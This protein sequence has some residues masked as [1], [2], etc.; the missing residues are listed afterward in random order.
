LPW[1]PWDINNPNPQFSKA[2][3]TNLNLSNFNGIEAM[4]LKNYCFEVHLNGITSEPNFM[5]FYQ[6]VQKLLV[7]DTEIDRQTGD[8][9]SLNLFLESR[10][11][12]KILT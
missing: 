4:G 5:K 12:N 8:L 2:H 9:L 3:L 6:A 10:L 7:G 11:K 1:L